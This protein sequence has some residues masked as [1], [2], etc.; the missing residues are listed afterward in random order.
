MLKNHWSFETFLW[1]QNHKTYFNSSLSRTG[2]EKSAEWV[3][4]VFEVQI[5]TNK[6]FL[7]HY[8]AYRENFWTTVQIS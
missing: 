8:K 3:K 1:S 7:P 5:F 6:Y 2:K 4:N